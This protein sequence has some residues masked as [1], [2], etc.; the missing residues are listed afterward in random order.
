VI[1][2]WFD[3]QLES[4]VAVAYQPSLL[5]Q[6]VDFRHLVK[7]ETCV[8]LLELLRRRRKEAEAWVNDNIR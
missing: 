5:P 8:G 1:K 7:V 3:R 4:P 2:T 6:E